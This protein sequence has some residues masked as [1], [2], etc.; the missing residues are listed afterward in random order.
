MVGSNQLAQVTGGEQRADPHTRPQPQ[1]Y[2][3]LHLGLFKPCCGA[4]EVYLDCHL[5]CKVRGAQAGGEQR[6]LEKL[7]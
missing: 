6:R 4:G 1:P 5:H 3:I 2:V 7:L